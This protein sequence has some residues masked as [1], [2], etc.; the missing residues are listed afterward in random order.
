LKFNDDFSD[1][2]FELHITHFCRSKNKDFRESYAPP[3]Q[4]FGLVRVIYTHFSG[5][6]PLSAPFSNQGPAEKGAKAH[7]E[8]EMGNTFAFATICSTETISSTIAI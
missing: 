7:Q 1:N 5:L 2:F 3:C 4:T 8:K 6:K